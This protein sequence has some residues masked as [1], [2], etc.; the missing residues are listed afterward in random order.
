M[1]NV[2][3]HNTCM[4]CTWLTLIKLTVVGQLL[5]QTPFRNLIR[6]LSA[7][8]ESQHSGAQ[9]D[10]LLI[11]IVQQTESMGPILQHK[12]SFDDNLSAVEFTECVAEWLWRSGINLRGS[13]HGIFYDICLRTLVCQTAWRVWTRCDLRILRHRA[14]QV[15]GNGR[16]DTRTR[17]LP[18]CVQLLRAQFSCAGAEENKG[19]H[20]DKSR[21][22]VNCLSNM[23]KAR[24]LDSICVS[25][26]AYMQYIENGLKS[27]HEIW[28]S[29][30][31]LKF[32][33]TK[34][35]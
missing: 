22:S 28:N 10:F 13:G 33:H 11:H 1:D 12:V 16:Q 15:R 29:R 32:I 8:L 24:L 34:F 19:R 26:S 5:A 2:Q 25:L 14:A 20:E 27:F 3:K 23:A 17:A 35:C 4:G 6:I 31:L 21:M 7:V 30:W 9:S 18:V